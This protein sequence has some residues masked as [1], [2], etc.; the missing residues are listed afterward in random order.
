[1]SV[2]KVIE[3]IAE[4]EQGWE[5]ATKEALRVAS[6]SV[7]GIKSIWIS[8]FQALVKDNAVSTYRVNAKISFEVEES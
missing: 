6:Q 1:M 8:D 3:V 2:V 4:S 7:R 5:G